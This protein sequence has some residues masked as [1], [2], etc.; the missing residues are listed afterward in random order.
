ML[1]RPKE[2]KPLDGYRLNVLFDNGEM[3]IYDMSKLI[4]K[5]FYSRLKNKSLFNTVKVSDITLEWATGEDICP[6]ELYNNSKKTS[7]QLGHQ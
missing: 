3:K 4:E 5:P 1:I 2:V 6:H 7:S